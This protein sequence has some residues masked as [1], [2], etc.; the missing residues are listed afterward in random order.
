[1]MAPNYLG[2]PGGIPLFHQKECV[3]AVGVSGIDRDDEPV[4]ISGAQ[5]FPKK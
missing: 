1:M 5:L 3:G 2:V 4:A